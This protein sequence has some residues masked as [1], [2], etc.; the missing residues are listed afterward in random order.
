MSGVIQLEKHISNKV[1]VGNS[2]RKKR[3]YSISRRR[4][5]AMGAL[6]DRYVEFKMN[7]CTQTADALCKSMATFHQAVLAEKQ[8]PEN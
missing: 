3:Y 2:P 7:P 6:D 1:P 4:F 5:R 8:T